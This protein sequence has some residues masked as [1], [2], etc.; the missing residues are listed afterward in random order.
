MKFTL[1]ILIAALIL[2]LLS[3]NEFEAK[4]I[5]RQV[6]TIRQLMTDPSC[7]GQPK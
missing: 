5:D 3:L 1:G 4:V 2:G 6:Q 7:T